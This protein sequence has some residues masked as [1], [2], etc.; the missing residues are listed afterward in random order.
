[1]GNLRKISE[2]AYLYEIGTTS[3][4]KCYPW[5]YIPHVQRLFC[6]QNVYKYGIRFAG[7]YHTNAAAA[8]VYQLFNECNVGS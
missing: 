4:P 8:I 5:L 3:Y 7:D 2:A 6:L 1:M